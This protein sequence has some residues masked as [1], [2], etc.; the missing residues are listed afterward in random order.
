MREL[1]DGRP[2]TGRQ[3]MKLGL[4]DAIGGEQDARQWLAQA[5]G[6]SADLPVE[7]V[8]SGSYARRALSSGLGWLLTELWKS[9]LSQGVILD[10][11]QV[12]WQRSGN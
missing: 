8:S 1:A 7:E 5:K 2:Y 9:V 6:V 3:A 10:G 11:A 12:V 4:V